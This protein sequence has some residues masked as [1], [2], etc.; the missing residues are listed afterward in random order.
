MSQSTN[1]W[2]EE[3]GGESDKRG[4]RAELALSQ[5]G[6]YHAWEGFLYFLG[7]CGPSRSSAIG[8]SILF[9]RVVGRDR[10]KKKE[11]W[12]EVGKMGWKWHGIKRERKKRAQTPSNGNGNGRGY[13][14]RVLSR[15]WRT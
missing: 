12:E 15:L 4:G 10:K 11:R 13:S 5:G 1:S 8:S 2:E 3:H 9:C 6:A 14:W 7:C